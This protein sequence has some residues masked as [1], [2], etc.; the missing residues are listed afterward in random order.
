LPRR[1][2]TGHSWVATSIFEAPA[3]QRRGLDAPC[4]AITSSDNGAR[5]GGISIGLD[6]GNRS[7]PRPIGPQRE[8]SRLR[9]LPTHLKPSGKDPNRRKSNPGR[10]EKEK[11]RP[12]AS[13]TARDR[14][15]PAT[16]VARRR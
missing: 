3:T 2:T 12:G 15:A 11:A 13:E 5:V 7:N 9:L 14:S 6:P 1:E 4:L 10:R 8:I 16:M